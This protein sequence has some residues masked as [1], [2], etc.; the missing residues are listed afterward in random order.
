MYKTGGGPPA[1]TDLSDLD[2]RVVGMFSDQFVPLSNMCD[3]DAS[4]IHIMT[5]PYEVKISC[6]YYWVSQPTSR[7]PPFVF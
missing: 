6:L 4:Y 2:V 1:P 5:L 7:Y 3:D